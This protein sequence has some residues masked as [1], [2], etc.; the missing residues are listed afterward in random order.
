MNHNCSTLCILTPEAPGYKCACPEN[1]IL[2]EDGISCEANCTSA[3][4][5][6]A[7]TY[8]C[9]NFWLKCDT[10][11]DCGDGSD[12]PAD[13]PP[14]H[15]NSGQFQ[16]YNSRCIEPSLLCNGINDC[17]DNSDELNCN[18][19]TCMNTQFKCQPANNVSSFCISAS[20]RCD[21]VNDCP[22]GD[23]EI[24]CP[25]NKCQTTQ[26][27][28]DNGKC[29]PSVWVCDGDNDCGDHSDEMQ[30]CQNRKCA[31]S[32][33]FRYDFCFSKKNLVLI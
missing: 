13:C 14:Y 10:Q 20:K 11:D 17:Q 9:I 3:Q 1:F 23:D 32:D 5:V 15:C 33:N 30:D 7:S 2:G 25:P 27:M 28:C 4:F 24:N 31:T 29:I 19:Y 21:R 22:M 6:C 18:D 16:C 26:H 8:K 12:E